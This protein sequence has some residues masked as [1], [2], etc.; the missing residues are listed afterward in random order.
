MHQRLC[1]MGWTVVKVYGPASD[2]KK[3]T[4]ATILSRVFPSPTLVSFDQLFEYLSNWDKW[5]TRTPRE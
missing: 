5:A 1:E 3:L 2:P 4:Q